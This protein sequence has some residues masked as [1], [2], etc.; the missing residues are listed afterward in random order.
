[1][2]KPPRPRAAR[3]SAAAT[4]VVLGLSLTACQANGPAPSASEA[5]STSPTASA[6]PSPTELSPEDEAI[7]QAERALREYS[8]V[9]DAVMKEPVDFDRD[10][11]EAVAIGSGLTS[12]QDVH[13]AMVIQGLHS[14]GDTRI[15]SIEVAEVDLTH[16]PKETPP[17]IPYVQFTVCSDVSGSRIINEAGKDATR[18]DRKPRVVQRIGVANYEYPDGQWLVAVAELAE[19]KT[20]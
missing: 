4:V 12:L 2:F 17:Q 6:S 9:Y 14:E 20:C 1:M 7:V 15:E 18:P 10:Q 11:F 13:R 5:V 16:R 19:D 3:L 8:R